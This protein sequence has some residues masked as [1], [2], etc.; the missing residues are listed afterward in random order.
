M[1]KKNSKGW[2][3]DSDKISWTL[4]RYLM[5]ERDGSEKLYEGWGK[6]IWLDG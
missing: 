5:K 1:E 4:L 2:F 3:K 6:G